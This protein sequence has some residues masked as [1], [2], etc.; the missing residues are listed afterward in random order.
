[1]PAAGKTGARTTKAPA[2][3]Q[4]RKTPAKRKPV[5]KKT[6]VGPASAEAQAIITR[7]G[8][9]KA[10]GQALVRA[11]TI[12]QEILMIRAMSEKR[13]EKAGDAAWLR[14]FGEMTQRVIALADEMDIDPNAI[15]AVEKAPGAAP[16]TEKTEPS[17]SVPVDRKSRA[18]ELMK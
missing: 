7:I 5:K 3:K 9:D 6:S 11:E 14:V 15:N 16:T 12:A 4:P 1:M 8:M 17:A 10:E 13:V 2:G 18:R